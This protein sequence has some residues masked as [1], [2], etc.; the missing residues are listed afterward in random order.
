MTPKT[1]AMMNNRN[2][3]R[4]KTLRGVLVEAFGVLDFV[5]RL[6]RAVRPKQPDMM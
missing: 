4:L 1:S 2:V 3:L 5:K 6:R